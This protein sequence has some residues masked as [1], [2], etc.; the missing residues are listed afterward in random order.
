MAAADL[1]VLGA[2]IRTMDPDRPWATAVA[3]SDGVL[4]AVGDDAE[5][6]ASCHAGTTV[7]DGTGAVVTPGLVDGHHHLFMGA[8]VGRGV[9][10]D[11]VH[12]LDRMRDLLRAERRRVGPGGWLL[13]FATEYETFAGPYHHD[14]LDEAAGDGPML[15]WALDLHT[16]FVNA[17]A[18]RQAGVTGPRRFDDASIVVCDDADRP[19]G[20]LREPSAFGLVQQV[21]PE[22]TRQQKL[23][24]YAD[25]I[26]RQNQVGLTGIH[27]MDGDPNTVDLLAELEGRGDL[28]LRV[29][30]HQFVYPTTGDD[31]VA[32]MLACRDRRGRR[33]QA[34]GV[35]LMVDGVIDT[36]TAWLEQPD[37]F[38]DGQDPM[39]PEFGAYGRRVRAFHDAGFRVAT[40]AIGDRAVREV[41]D[42]YAGLPGGSAGRH[43]IE[44]IETAPDSTVARFAAERVTASMQPIHLRWLKPDLSDPWSQR[45][46]PTRCAHGMRSGD[47]SAAGALVVLGSDWPVAPFDP[48]LGFFAA[49][50]RRAHDVAD[51]RPLGS[52]RPLTGLETLAGYTVNPALAVGQSGSAG[53]LRV[54]YRADLV[55]WAD[56]PATCPVS[57]VVDL[58]VRFTVV[59]G[60]LA[61]A[62]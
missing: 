33:W 13:G 55:G 15:L 46:D 41:L 21:I 50:Q 34:D 11:R 24:W 25:A 8:E 29:L 9:D 20:E 52:S 22:P 31:E 37:S 4:V 19:T 58:P 47:L 43:R 2:R 48:R 35:K 30:L 49:Q 17:E 36:G 60:A 53:M 6:R 1:A 59:D 14:L 56:D 51:P 28:T 27:L 18:L 40:H 38:G 42:V 26:R 54:G 39:W 32:A 62:G 45:L 23:D 3:I 7:I 5:V 44:H 16:A 57:D 12:T 61:D 10:L